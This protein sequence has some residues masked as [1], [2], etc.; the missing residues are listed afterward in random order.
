MRTAHRGPNPK[1]GEDFRPDI[2]PILR[3]A[4]EDYSWLLS[5][6]YAYKSALK[7]VGDHFQLTKRQRTAIYRYSCSD[8]QVNTRKEKRIPA[9]EILGE[10]LWIDALN[11]IITIEAALSNGFLIKCRDSCCRDMA[12]VYSNYLIIPETKP[13]IE[14]IGQMLEVLEIPKAVWVVDKPVSNSKK[15][16][17]LINEVAMENEWNWECELV[18]SPDKVLAETDAAI[19][20]SDSNVIDK[21]GKWFN[22]CGQIVKKHRN[23]S[24]LL[25][26]TP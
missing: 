16:I 7:L 19:V 8:E 14:M 5:K 21:C 26:L 18:S 4:G 15:L 23:G 13:A 3:C 11:T 20:T 2:L 17:S 25:D 24:R 6:G 10:E 22:L 9:S 1:D 12:E